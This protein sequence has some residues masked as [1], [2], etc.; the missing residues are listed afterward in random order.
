MGACAGS[1]E[2]PSNVVET[3]DASQDNN[4]A[5][6]KILLVG[7]SGSGKSSVIHRYTEGVFSDAYISTVGVDF[8][9]KPVTVGTKAI[10]LQI[11]DTAGQE[12]FRTITANFFRGSH[13]IIVVYDVTNSDSFSNVSQWLE[14][15]RKY[16][17]V[18]V[19]LILLGNKIDLVESRQVTTE[20]GKSCA[21]GKN[22]TFFESSAKDDT[23]VADVFEHVAK[24][25]A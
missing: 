15:V 3:T 17:P 20:E 23:N 8:K 22:M 1:E 19:K 2:Q 4:E 25:L 10:K 9:V 13:A 11:W 21:T 16:A 6:K 18:D 24:V 5:V 14:E 12:R 7:D